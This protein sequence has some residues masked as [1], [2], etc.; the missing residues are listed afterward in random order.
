MSS[1]LSYTHHWLL[2]S[3]AGQENTLE[4]QTWNNRLWLKEYIKD[5]YCH[6]THLSFTQ[7]TSSKILGWMKLAG[8][9]VMENISNLK[10]RTSTNLNGERRTKGLLVKIKKENGNVNWKLNIK[11]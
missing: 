8:I 5:V 6:P 11:N 4:P 1:K 2:K 3:Y 10:Y 9:K 7:S